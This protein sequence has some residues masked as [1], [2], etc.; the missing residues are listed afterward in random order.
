MAAILEEV[1]I[2]VEEVEHQVQNASLVVVDIPSEHQEGHQEGH[3]GEH[4]EGHQ[5]GHQGEH[6]RE[7]QEGRQEEVQGV[8][9]LVQAI[10]EVVANRMVETSLVEEV[11]HLEQD[12]FLLAVAKL[13]LVAILDLLS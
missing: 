11:E 3:Q 6:Q 2:L 1:A 5:E 4:Q 13:G 12:A 10:P 7:H 8:H 9:L